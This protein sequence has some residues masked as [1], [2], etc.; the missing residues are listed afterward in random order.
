MRANKLQGKRATEERIRLNETISR[1]A[2][3]KS[4]RYKMWATSYIGRK[5]IRLFGKENAGRIL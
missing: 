1:F 3:L 5:S 4:D 2:Y